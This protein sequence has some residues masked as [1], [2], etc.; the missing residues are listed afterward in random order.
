ML[1]TFDYF[2]SNNLVQLGIGLG[3]DIIVDG[4]ESIKEEL[5]TP[6]PGYVICA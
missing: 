6:I 4:R 5:L 2:L 3:N 1:Q